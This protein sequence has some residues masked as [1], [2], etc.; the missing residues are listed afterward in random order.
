[1]I[2]KIIKKSLISK[3]ENE[4][5]EIK[6]FIRVLEYVGYS[7]R[8]GIKIGGFNPEKIDLLKIDG[9]IAENDKYDL[10]SLLHKYSEVLIDKRIV[11]IDL[12]AFTS[13]RVNAS[14]LSALLR[15]EVIMK[16]LKIINNIRLY[17]EKDGKEI[18]LKNASSG[19]LLI[20]STL[21]FI[22]SF[23]KENSII[24][25]D[26]P[27]NSLHPK[28]QKEYVEK[29]LDMFYYYRPKIILA[30]HSPLIIPLESQ[31]INLFSIEKGRV[32]KM[33]HNT[34][35]NEELLSDIFKIVTPENRYLSNHMI[36]IINKFDS[37]EM[38]LLNANQEID[39]YFERVYDPRQE[40][41]LRGVKDIINTI[42][43]SKTKRT[44]HA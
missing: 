22:S 43:A 24:L 23:I 41:F 9:L 11:S 35:N 40:E 16:K 30:T 17:L 37:N 6:S 7:S 44:D 36:E 10:S 27:E 21:V 29:I 19:E 42:R 15:Y 8:I 38:T 34:S 12:Y 14:A 31:P 25:I 28:W 1:M 2:N 13:G 33:V 20:L 4:N 32:K 26:E 18:E 3:N 39:L 5:D